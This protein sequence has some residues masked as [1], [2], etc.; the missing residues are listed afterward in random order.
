MSLRLGAVL[1]VMGCGVAVL[2]HM[3]DAMRGFDEDHDHALARDD[4]ASVLSG[5]RG[6]GRGSGGRG[7]ARGGQNAEEEDVPQTVRRLEQRLLQLEKSLASALGVVS[8]GGAPGATAAHGSQVAEPSGVAVA[9]PPGAEGES[10][11]AG[12]ASAAGVAGAKLTWRADFKCGSRDGEGHAQC[13]PD[14]DHPCCSSLGWCGGTSQH[15]KCPK[16]VDYRRAQGRP[17]ASGGTGSG[18]SGVEHRSATTSQEPRGGP[19]TVAVIIPFRDREGHLVK[20]KKF[21]KWF[22]AEG[23]VPPT[24][25]RWEIFVVEQFDSRT[26]NRGWTFNVGFALATGQ[27]SASPDIGESEGLDIDCAVIQDIDYLPEKGVD[28]SDCKVPMQLSSE[29][30]RFDWKTPYL[31]SAGGIVGMSPQHW[32]KINGFGNEYFGWGGEDDELHHRLRLTNLLYGDCYPFCKA[33]DNN[34]GRTGLSIKRPAKGFGRFSGKYMHSANHTKRITSAKDYDR[35]IKQL[36]EIRRGSN[37]WKSDG[38]SNLAF[39]VVHNDVDESDVKS[40]G[41]VY[42]HVKIRR[43]KSSFKLSQLGL[44]LPA[45]FCKGSDDTAISW[46]YVRL[47][48]IVPWSIADLRKRAAEAAGQTLESCPGAAKANFLLVDRRQHVAKILQPEADDAPSLLVSFYRSLVN[49]EDDGV[50]VADTRSASDI[51]KAFVSAGAFAELLGTYT[52]CKSPMKELTKYSLHAGEGC[53]GSGWDS[54]QGGTFV[55][56]T[57]KSDDVVAVSWCDNT[58]YWVQRMVK[59]EK[60]PEHW[61]GMKWVHGGTFYASPGDSFCV[62]SRM[63]NTEGKSFS[64]LLPKANCAGDGFEHDFSFGM[65]KGAWK[66]APLTLCVVPGA[67]AKGSEQASALLAADDSE[68]ACGGARATSGLRFAARAPRKGGSEGDRLFCAARVGGGGGGRGQFYGDLREGSETCGKDELGFLVPASVSR[69][70]GGTGAGASDP[71]P[72]PR[73]CAQGTGV[74]SGDHCSAS[75][76][77]AFEAPSALDVAASTPGPFALAKSPLYMLVE[78]AQLCFSFVCPG[79]LARG[80]ER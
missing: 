43:G 76:A 11:G 13:N 23:R 47:G 8:D 25:A 26:F 42:H 34:K 67:G 73:I 50:I 30:D 71:P 65:S 28:Y 2:I 19:K 21:W 16:C 29:I 38:L 27:R 51:A 49:P 77:I 55:A 10:S 62:G 58:K 22:A 3:R 20:F 7:G 79:V 24:V 64:R 5:A 9:K 56:H 46:I 60:C 52:V 59:G 69:E 44:A 54:I 33:N 1:V 80:R 17:V 37:R 32:R 74:A 53:S 39:R 48:D 12:A 66:A 18:S 6:G 45:A 78:E 31:Q 72:R 75:A 36:N 61:A 35:N 68:S 15:C 40:S 70:E 41:I 14:S 57:K 4:L 63:T